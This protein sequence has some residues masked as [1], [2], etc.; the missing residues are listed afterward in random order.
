MVIVPKKDGTLHV[1]IGF[2][3]LNAQSK[4]DAYPVPQ[5][6]D[7]LEKIAQAKFITTVD[8][9]KGYWQTPLDPASRQY[10]AFQ[11]LVGLYQFKVLPFGLQ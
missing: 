3:K 4:F 1:C 5:V 9:C 10:T 7:L 6:D 11:T 8:L 2:N